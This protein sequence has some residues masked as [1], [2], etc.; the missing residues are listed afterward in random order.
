VLALGLGSLL[1]V[2]VLELVL[3]CLPVNSG[4]ATAAVDASD[5]ILHFAPGREFTYSKGWAF[6][7]VHRG[8]V[9]G[10]GFVNDQEYDPLGGGP[11]LA[12]V[13]DSYVE[14]LMLPWIETLHGRLAAELD[15]RGRVYSFGSSGAP[16]SQYLAVASW[17]RERFRPQGLAVVVV[18]ND[19]D[20]SLLR[21]KRR[22]GFHYFREEEGGELVLE[23][24]DYQPG[25]LR[26]WARR[27]ALLRYLWLNAGILQALRAPAAG[28]S[29]AASHFGN[30]RAAYDPERLGASRAA[31]E[32]FLAD[33]PGCAGLAPERIVLLVDGQRQAIYDPGLAQAAE[34]SFFGVLRAYFLERARELGYE[35]VDLHGV[36]AEQHGRDG[37]RFEFDSDAHWNARGHELA[38][39]AVT[40]TRLW[41]EVFAGRP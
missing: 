4:L 10:S 39:H 1:V 5:P 34:Q 32:R 8:R 6:D 24:V 30:T 35:A 26:A 25:R 37:S 21:Y 28:G 9:N 11:L 19:F 23:R 16:L 12:V 29:D 38:A 41:R 27:S 33:L 18:G 15:G 40:G 7:L 22:P 14:A 20:E 31:V 13:G 17:I 2:G 3:R 36:F